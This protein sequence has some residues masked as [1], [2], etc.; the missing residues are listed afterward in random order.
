MSDVQAKKKKQMLSSYSIVFLVLIVVA[1]LTWFVPQSVVIKN[2]GTKEIIYNAIMVEG[3]VVTGQGLQPMGLWDILMAPIR[4]FV[5]A[6]PVGF[7]ILMAGSFLHLMNHVGAMNSAIGWLLKRFTG[8]ALI[9][10]L[11][12]VSALF[13]A[14]YGLWEEIPAYSMVV[15]PLFVL[16]GYDVITGIGVLFVG[17]TAGNMA[18][19]VNPFSL[20]AA[21]GAIGTDGLSMGSGMLLR[22]VIFFVLYVVGLVY[23][24][25]YADTVKR[26]PTRSIVHGLDIKTLVDED[27]KM[28]EFTSRKAWSI[29]LL[30]VIILALVC[31]YMPWDAI[32]FAD[33]STMK[34]VV[35]LPFR[36]L[37]KVPILGEL[38]GAGHYTEFGDWYF[39]EFAFVFLVGAL[40][41][42]PINKIPEPEFVREFVAGA[43]EMLG[44]C[45]RPHRGKRDF[46]HHG[47]QNGRYERN[48]RVL[49]P[50]CPSRCSRLG[51]CH[52]SRPCLCG[53]W[54]LY[55]VDK[56]CCR[57]YYADSWGRSLCTFPKCSHWF[58][59]WPGHADCC[60]YDWS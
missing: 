7:A 16:A 47:Q 28:E 39:D 45:S 2:N 50:E 38:F 9:I 17:A 56:R 53:H 33:G 19:I 11:M 12:F 46:C 55:A 44:V 41:L 35:N 58:H 31:G 57:H 8:K 22:I 27:H 59:W 29:T 4:G 42:G 54:V 49:D 26:D 18:S 10:V 40:L 20:G 32:K 30:V 24:L 6:A 37:A 25:H 51:F 15:V 36:S 1:I 52:C 14:V 48:V 13:G 21:V 60:F 23:M 43:R 3:K 34:D 5:K